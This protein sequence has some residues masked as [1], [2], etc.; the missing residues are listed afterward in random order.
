MTDCCAFLPPAAADDGLLEVAGGDDE[1][2]TVVTGADCRACLPGLEAEG[3][4]AS[5][6]L[7]DDD[8]SRFLPQVGDGVGELTVAPSSLLLT[9]FSSVSVGFP[10]VSM[11]SA[12]LRL[13]PAFSSA[14]T[15]AIP[16]SSTL[17][18][19][20]V[21]FPGSVHSSVPP[22]SS[23]TSLSDDFSGGVLSALSG[24]RSAS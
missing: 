24:G 12:S 7:S 3:A 1:G 21:P 10:S 22:A 14:G 19:V 16:F 4:A 20:S 23:T 8:V 2:A 11:R 18:P 9:A 15:F 13:E 5:A 6:F 17:A